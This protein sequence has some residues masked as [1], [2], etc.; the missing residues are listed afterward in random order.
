MHSIIMNSITTNNTELFG[1]VM[2]PTLYFFG[3]DLF[4]IPVAYC[5]P[6]DS[7]ASSIHM[8]MLR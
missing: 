8:G 3:S 2:Q 1:S 4:M 7:Q 5:V 6:Q